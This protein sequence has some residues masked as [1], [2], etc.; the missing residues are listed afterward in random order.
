MPIPFPPDGPQ[1]QAAL[2]KVPTPQLQN[3]AAGRPPQP[4]G[5]VTPGPMGAAAE[6]L[7]ARGA[8]GAANQRQQAMQNNPANS[9]TI[10]Q[11]KDM[12]LQQKAQQLAAMGQQIQQKEQQLGV[13][14]ALMAKKAQDMQARESMGV[15]NL[16]IRPDM[17]TAMNGGIVF[18]G[19]G[20]VEGYARRGLVQDLG[21]LEDRM[22]EGFTERGIDRMVDEEEEDPLQ[23][24][25]RNIEKAAERR[26]LS[27]ES[28]MY[29]PEQKEA[30]ESKERERLGEQYSRY[31][32]GIAGL[33]EEAAAAIR[34]KPANTMQG[35]AAGLAALPAD[36]RNVRLA[37]LMAKL[38]GGVAGERARAEDRE[39]E[40]NKYL[41]DARRKAAAADLA[42]ER[43]QDTLARALRKSEQDDRLKADALLGSVATTEIESQRGIGALEET[44]RERDQRAKE[45]AE[46]MALD[47]EKQAFDVRKYTEEPQRQEYLLRLQAKLAR[48]NRP[49]SDQEK[50]IMRATL[51]M[52]DN[53][54]AEFSKD[55]LLNRGRGAGADGRPSFADYQRMVQDR[56]DR[57]TDRDRK[58]IG[59]ALGRKPTEKDIRDAITTEVRTEL[60]NE[61]G[62]GLFKGQGGRGSTPSTKTPPA[63]GTVMEGYKFKG[64]DPSKQENWEKI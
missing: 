58:E 33:D 24:R 60:E 4:T 40:A 20:G 59:A 54:I 3:Y 57:V 21:M 38:S 16:P 39:R 53:E 32:Q 10:F 26:R 19:G 44:R 46:R 25:I 56:L 30:L 45:A 28:A 31:K 15:A 50:L 37:G 14:G 6:A 12:E 13:L 41:I 5:Q 18:S 1:V 9:P 49:P 51:G 23:R 61:F 7:N 64:G 2:Q 52:S 17:F 43:N 29:T 11:Q 48:E 35:I 22:A 42:E 62:A 55:L 34:G 27:A 63:V 8:M 47:R 36:L